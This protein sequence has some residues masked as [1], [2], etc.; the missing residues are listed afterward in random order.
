[1]VW[2]NI[3]LGGLLIILTIFIHSFTTRYIVYLVVKRNIEN[4]NR[5]YRKEFWVALIVL[6]LLITTIFEACIWAVSYLLIH[7]MP[8][9]ETSLYFSIVTFTTLGYGDITLNEDW[10]LLASL[11]AAIGII[12][13]GWTTAIVMTVVQKLFFKK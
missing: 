1:M 13:F 3:L 9:F 6:V 8:V 11:E 5:K 7:A 2:N 4:M 10:R 12:I